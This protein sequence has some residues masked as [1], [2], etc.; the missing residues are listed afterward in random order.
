MKKGKVISCIICH[1]SVY[2]YPRDFRNKNTRFCSLKCKGIGFRGISLSFGTQF[3]QGLIPWNKGKKTGIITKGIFKK[4]FIP[5]NKGLKSLTKRLKIYS[6]NNRGSGRFCSNCKKLFWYKTR[7]KFCSRFCAGKYLSLSHSKECICIA[8]KKSFKIR[9]SYNGKGIFCSTKCSGS[10]K[11]REKSPSWKGGIK[12]DKDRRKS[13]EG[14]RWRKSVFAR[15]DFTCQHCGTKGGYIE[16]HHIKPYKPY[17]KL[18]FDLTNGITLC[19]SCHKK[20]DSYGAKAIRF[21]KVGQPTI[22]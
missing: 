20:T 16:A 8:C 18:R 6:T 2:R 7:Q 22:D 15:D 11:V 12:K 10:Y 3:K 1:K 9:L 21:Y 17:P 4:G 5:W 19:K 14:I 13:F